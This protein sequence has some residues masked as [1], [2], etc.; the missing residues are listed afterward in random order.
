MVVY[1]LQDRLFFANVHFFKRRIWAAVDAA[2]KPVR[3]LVLDA[4]SISGV[5][6]SA[7]EAVGEVVEGLHIRNITLV[8]ARAT[9]ELR[10]DFDGN[11]LTTLIGAD[12]FYPTVTTAVE[13]CAAGRD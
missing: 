6:A 11:G 1:R 8:V 13:A 9:D 4:G 12:H 2:P 7:S 10:Q 5:D 3:Y